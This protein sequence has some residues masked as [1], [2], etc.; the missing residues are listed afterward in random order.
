M[1]CV[2]EHTQPINPHNQHCRFLRTVSEQTTFSG[3]SDQCKGLWL[4]A[5]LWLYRTGESYPGDPM[6]KG[7][8]C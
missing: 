5:E 6:A 2:Y 1:N 7:G 3:Q 8:R 4:L